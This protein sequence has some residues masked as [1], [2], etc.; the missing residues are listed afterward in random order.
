[1][2]KS[3]KREEIFLMVK[4]S[5]YQS[6]MYGMAHT[7]LS[8]RIKK[9]TTAVVSK[10]QPDLFSESKGKS[11]AGD[12]EQWRKVVSFFRKERGVAHQTKVE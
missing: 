6:L 10:A 1:M 2:L 11:F 9:T 5:I 8:S 12:D 4:G 3:Q 7:W